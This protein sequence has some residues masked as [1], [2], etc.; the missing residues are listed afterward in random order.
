MKSAE[1]QKASLS[2]EELLGFMI[3]L[4]EIIRKEAR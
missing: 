3:W 1:A 2:L 4:A